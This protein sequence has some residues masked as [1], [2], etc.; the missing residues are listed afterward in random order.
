MGRKPCKLPV[1]S[2]GLWTG[3]RYLWNVPPPG[4]SYSRSSPARN[5]YTLRLE[6]DLAVIQSSL[7]WMRGTSPRPFTVFPAN[8]GRIFDFNDPAAFLAVIFVRAM[9][10]EG[11]KM[12]FQFGRPC[13]IYID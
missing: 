9:V 2:R 13:H 7:A 8:E 1:V 5:S 4:I 6:M 12:N 10:G 3:I 11:L